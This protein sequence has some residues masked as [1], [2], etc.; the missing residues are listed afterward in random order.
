MRQGQING[1]Y[2]AAVLPRLAVPAVHRQPELASWAGTP[3]GVRVHGQ[4]TAQVVVYVRFTVTDIE[5][6][7]M[8]KFVPRRRQEGV[9]GLGR[10]IHRKI[11]GVSRFLRHTGIQTPPDHF[12]VKTIVDR[13]LPQRVRQ[14]EP[15]PNDAPLLQYRFRGTAGL[16]HVLGAEDILLMALFPVVRFK[17]GG[18]FFAG[19]DIDGCIGFPPFRGNRNSITAPAELL[20]IRLDKCAGE[21]G[22]YCWI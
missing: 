1:G 12:R 8:F 6:T 16:R 10:H 3:D 22:R 5:Q 7:R 4:D 19:A 15:H 13:G 11:P 17:P 21:K 20:F 9:H 2:T 18:G 14:H